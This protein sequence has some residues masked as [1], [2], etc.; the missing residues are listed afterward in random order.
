MNYKIAVNLTLLV[1]SISCNSP[2]Q[3]DNSHEINEG[4]PSTTNVEVDNVNSKVDILE[5]R[6]VFGDFFLDFA[7]SVHGDTFAIQLNSKKVFSEEL[8]TQIEELSPP[9]KEI[10]PTFNIG[11]LPAEFVTQNFVTK[12]FDSLYLYSATEGYLGALKFIGYFYLEDDI[13]GYPAALF[14]CNQKSSGNHYVMNLSYPTNDH[15]T[16]DFSSEIITKKIE[17]WIRKKDGEIW[18]TQFSIDS[19]SLDTLCLINYQ[20]KSNFYGSTLLRIKS[21]KLFELV[22][23]LDDVVISDFLFTPMINMNYPVLLCRFGQSET[24]FTWYKPLVFDST[25]YIEVDNY[26]SISNQ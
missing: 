25:G 16:Y 19:N 15:L 10:G 18:R 1:V 6:V 4:K 23:T 9:L 11:E 14:E 2:Y 12:F 13:S 5:E 7:E 20:L 22:S 21:G 3:K 24:D 17:A 26:F 8:W